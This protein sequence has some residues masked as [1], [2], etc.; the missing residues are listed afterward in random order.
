MIYKYNQFLKEKIEIIQTD[1]PSL[2][3]QKN[4]LNDLEKH[5]KEF[6]QKKTDL[7]NIYLTYTDE[8]DLINKLSAR[9][10][11]KKTGNKKQIEFEN[12]L[13]S[14]FSSA[15]EK[16]RTLKDLEKSV[17]ELGE[18]LKDKNE[19]LQKNPSSKDSVGQEIESVRKDLGEKNKQIQKISTEIV[20]LQRISNQRLLDMQQDSKDT[21]RQVRSEIK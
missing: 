1:S 10:F 4:K 11:I 12:P 20:Q 17:E 21:N 18:K 15:C 5:T 13:F 9:G 6:L 19:Y 8:G 3:S 2:A 16:T 14:V 7:E